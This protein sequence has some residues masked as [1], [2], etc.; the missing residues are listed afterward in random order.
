M[1]KPKSNFYFT[2]I[3]QLEKDNEI[4]IFLFQKKKNIYIIKLMRVPNKS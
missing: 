1:N 2:Y 4:T 3:R